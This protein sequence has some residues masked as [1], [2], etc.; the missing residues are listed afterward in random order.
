[1]ILINLLWR[2]S[3]VA[4]VLAGADYPG[5]L[6]VPQNVLGWKG[7]EAIDDL[8]RAKPPWRLFP[9]P[10][11]VPVDSPHKLSRPGDWDKLIKKVKE[12]PFNEKTILIVLSLH[13][14]SDSQGAYFCPDEMAD[15][16]EE[17]IYLKRVITSLAELPQNKEKILVIEGAQVPSN[18]QLGMLHNDFA[19]E[20]E[21]LDGEIRKVPHLWVLSAAGVDQRCWASEGLGRTVFC[22]Y[23]IEAFQ[24]RAV[25]DDG[26]LSLQELHDYLATNVRSWVWKARGAIQEPVLLPSARRQGGGG[27]G[28]K[29][30]EPPSDKGGT[31]ATASR[32]PADQIYLPTL[33]TQLGAQPPG[34][35]AEGPPTAWNDYVKRDLQSPHPAVYTPGEWAR[36]KAELLR[37]DELLRIGASPQADK[38]RPMMVGSKEALERGRFLKDELT[39]VEN[40]LAM[41]ALEGLVGPSEEPPPG[42]GYFWKASRGL[43]SKETWKALVDSNPDTAQGRGRPSVRI[44]ADRFLLSQASQDPGKNLQ[45]VFEKLDFTRRLDFPH[46]PTEVHFARMLARWL[47]PIRE[48]SGKQ[49]DAVGR[50]IA[51]RSKAERAALGSSPNSKAERAAL[52]ISPDSEEYSY[53]EQVYPWI[54]NQVKDADAER[55]LGEDQLFSSEESAWGRAKEAIIRAEDLY[56]RVDKRAATIRKALGTRDRALARLPEISHWVADRGPDER[57]DELVSEVETLWDK[58]HR[59][60]EALEKPGDSPGLTDLLKLEHDVSEG[61]DNVIDRMTELAA[62]RLE[63]VRSRNWEEISALAAIPWGEKEGGFTIR[64][65]IW[66]RLSNIAKEDREL[67]AMDQKTPIKFSD[68]ERAEAEARARARA[69]AQARMALA[70]LGRRWFDEVKDS[71]NGEQGNHASTVGSVL[72]LR[73]AERDGRKKWWSIISEVGDR[74]RERWGHLA[75]EIDKL[76]DERDGIADFRAFA[77]G[78]VKAD[79]LERLLEGGTPRTVGASTEAAAKLREARVHDLLIG[80]AD[81]AWEDH[82]YY[83]DGKEP[84]FRAVGTLFINDADHLFD[85]SLPVREARKQMDREGKITAA[86]VRKQVTFTSETKGQL[87]FEIADEGHVPE[88]LPVVKPTAEPTIKPPLEP[89]PESTGYR[90]VSRGKLQEK[91]TIAVTVGNRL[92]KRYEEDRQEDGLRPVPSSVRLDGFFRGQEFDAKTDALIYPVPDTVEIG[93]PPA[94]PPDAS[95]A[96]RAN[97][98]IFRRFGEGT[99]SIAIVLDCSG[100]MLAETV[101]GTTKFEEAQ[102]ALRDVLGSVPARTRLSLWTFSQLPPGVQALFQGDP[103]GNEPELTIDP[104]LPMAPWDPRQ[105]EAVVARVAQQRPYLSTPL[106]TAMWTAAKSDLASAKGLKTLLVLTDGD[107]TEL[108]KNKPR[109]NPRSLSV[110]DFIVENFKPL[111]ITVNMVFFTPQ[112]KQQEIQNALRRFRPALAQL[113]P[114]GNFGMA[115]NLRELK[116]ILR[117]G[118]RQELTFQVLRPDGKPVDEQPLD[119]TNPKEKEVWCRGLKPGYYKVR[120][121]AGTVVDRDVDLRDGDRMI[122]ELVEDGAGG[123]ACQRGLYSASREFKDRPSMGEAWRL[124]GLANK[125][126]RDGGQNR[127]EIVTALERKPERESSGPIRQVR[128]GMAWYRLSADVENRPEKPLMTRWRERA[129]YPGPVWH[130]DVPGWILRQAPDRPA[131][132]ILEAWWCDPDEKPQPHLTVKF[133]KPGAPGALSRKLRLDDGG[134]VTIESIVQEDHRVEV[135]P[136]E[137]KTMPCLVVRLE[138]PAGH[139][140][141]VDPDSLRWVNEVNVVGHEHRLYSQAGKYT[142]VFWPV[143]PPK[144]KQLTGLGLLDLDRLLKQAVEARNTVRMLPEV[145]GPPTE[146]DRIPDPPRVLPRAD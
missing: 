10:R 120:V 140:C 109:Y 138:F 71:S 80:M 135:A 72:A 30:A 93:S 142:G 117:R 32:L 98:E 77:N 122:I 33:V 45:T 19:R 88:G 137:L 85:E 53:C 96:V 52:G 134:F 13:G 87:E 67:L 100:S 92:G 37:Y 62:P 127:L 63:K 26:Y 12:R 22:H 61:M 78:L 8:A 123:I 9:H 65:K 68:K 102:T 89:D 111:G 17:R 28:E 130:F 116:D 64:E 60:A 1:V 126:R 39:S 59:L 131:S 79:R 81:R 132:P 50:A 107:D 36:Y 56:T 41:S 46:P 144:F 69:I 129:Y 75:G 24:G 16:K 44:R 34:P 31:T 54:R 55:R 4:L 139:R 38:I 128:P 66:D 114:P 103:R 18:W 118:L 104:L 145:L 106:V 57:Q 15:P 124:T 119:V 110:K 58:T 2:P 25:G 143:N 48:P 3:S 47:K 21:K 90:V 35:S 115:N 133:D 99:G 101:P 23:L 95:I 84:Y 5:N 108:E 141:L 20:L 27:D 86:A 29:T 74:V 43:K 97:D 7:L 94:D 14:G 113:Q 121:H 146:E 105:T 83:Q 125:I 6:L 76:V 112:A 136:N 49:L 73:E 42:L 51:L 70:A 82:W 11:L 40:N 91:E